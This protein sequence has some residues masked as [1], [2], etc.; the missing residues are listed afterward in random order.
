MDCPKLTKK[1]GFKIRKDSKY[2]RA[3]IVWE[4]NE[5]SSSSDSKSDECEN[6]ALMASHQSDDED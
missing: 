1:N 6:L 3:Y 4:D 2:K 5:I